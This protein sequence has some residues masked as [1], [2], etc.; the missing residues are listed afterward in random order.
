MCEFN[1]YWSVRAIFCIEYLHMISTALMSCFENRHR[2]G[3]N[4]LRRVKFS[5]TFCSL[6]LIRIKLGIRDVNVMPLS[7]IWM[8]L[9]AGALRRTLLIK[10]S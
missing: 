2:K 10:T 4:I 6:C 8:F 1:T 5:C 3:C 9:E 7:E